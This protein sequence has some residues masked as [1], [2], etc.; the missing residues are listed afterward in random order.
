MV[1]T[2]GST[3]VVLSHQVLRCNQP[4]WGVPPVP[5]IPATPAWEHSVLSAH[6]SRLWS[7]PCPLPP[8]PFPPPIAD[9][10]QHDFTSGAA[11]L[12]SSRLCSEVLY[13]EL[14]LPPFELQRGSSYLCITCLLVT[15]AKGSG[16]A[17]LACLAAAG[18]LPGMARRGSE[19]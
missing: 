13:K 5:A 18:G 15:A 2:A 3:D 12:T 10:A 6:S 16:A 9:G 8:L 14:Y 1:Y 19:R 11:L 7:T 4:R 17:V